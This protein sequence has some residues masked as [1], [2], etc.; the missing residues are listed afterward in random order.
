MKK[1]Y[2]AYAVLVI[3]VLIAGLLGVQYPMPVAPDDI[4][5]VMAEGDT[6]FTN[7]VASGDLTA[8][9]DIVAGDD[10]TVGGALAFGS[11]SLYPLGDAS[12]GNAVYCS[13]SGTFTA[14]TTVTN[15][16]HGLTTLT[17][18]YALMY[19]NPTT[20]AYQVSGV[21][22]GSTLTLTTWNVTSGAGTTGANVYYCVYGQP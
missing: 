14:T 6:N 11:S 3:A 2:V 20:T 9:D 4:I 22:S 12:D 21:V 5:Q 19:T 8:G 16:T 18:S 7:V 10:L 1:E 13:T 15:T 17:A